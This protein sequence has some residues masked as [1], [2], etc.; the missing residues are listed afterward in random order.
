MQR[1]QA[2]GY[3]PEGMGF[4]RGESLGAAAPGVASPAELV[5]AWVGNAEHAAD[6]LGRDFTETGVGVSTGAGSIVRVERGEPW[7]TPR[8]SAGSTERHDS[9]GLL[10]LDAGPRPPGG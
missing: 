10:V 2:T 9:A 7:S 1:I 8:S 3:V 6:M 4:A 5:A